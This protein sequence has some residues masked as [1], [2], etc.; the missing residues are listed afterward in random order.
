MEKQSVTSP[1]LKSPRLEREQSLWMLK[2]LALTSSKDQREKIEVVSRELGHS[3]FPFSCGSQMC[4]L[5]I[6]AAEERQEWVRDDID[7]LMKNI[8]WIA[9]RLQQHAGVCNTIHSIAPSIPIGFGSLF[10]SVEAMTSKAQSVFSGLDQNKLWELSGL[11]WG[12][13]VKRAA[14]TDTVAT[15]RESAAHN[16]VSGSCYFQSLARKKRHRQNESE[17]AEDVLDGVRN[18]LAKCG[19]PTNSLSVREDWQNAKSKERVVGRFATLVPRDNQNFRTDCA[20]AFEE[21][22]REKSSCFH[23]EWNGPWAPFSF[24]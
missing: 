24:V 21:L 6:C 16:A 20:R 18:I 5:V 4:G 10:S 15:P 14:A 13:T 12:L 8:D 19:F 11:E 2:S 23:F 3:V 22:A 1:V 17:I 7:E 9:P